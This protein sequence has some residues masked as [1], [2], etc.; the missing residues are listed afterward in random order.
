M[1]PFKVH[2]YTQEAKHALHL[3]D[4]E[5]EDVTSLLD[6]AR[7]A[8][9]TKEHATLKYRLQIFVPR[10]SKVFSVV[11]D[12]E[13]GG[14]VTISP[15]RGNDVQSVSRATKLALATDENIGIERI[16]VDQQDHYRT[17]FTIL[18]TQPFM[19]VRTGRARCKHFIETFSR[20]QL[21]DLEN[22]DE[23]REYVIWCFQS[24]HPEKDTNLLSILVKT[25]NRAAASAP[26]NF[27]WLYPQ[28]KHSV[29]RSSLWI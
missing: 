17:Q 16:H 2:Y 22:C 7:C 10:L 11:Y 4:L 13:D 5:E 23:I 20:E 21:L 8:V 3:N 27:P 19:E 6:T 12:M 24:L 25:N 15:T 1:S 29:R 26:Y 18:A 9:R 14:V 28:E